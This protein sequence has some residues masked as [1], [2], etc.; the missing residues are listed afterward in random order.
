MVIDDFS[1]MKAPKLAK[2]C[3]KLSML[4]TKQLK[5]CPSFYKEMMR[6][7]KSQEICHF[8]DFIWVRGYAFQRLYPFRQADLPLGD[9]IRITG[10][11][12]KVRDVPVLPLVTAA[13]YMMSYA[14]LIQANV[15]LFRLVA[16]VP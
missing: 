8:T 16:A 5:C 9:W 13:V 14:H 15:P 7:G 12:G 6:G 2:A 11:G 4:K 10:K 3:Q 1:W